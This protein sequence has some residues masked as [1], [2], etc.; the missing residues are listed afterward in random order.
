M[1]YFGKIIAKIAEIAVLPPLVAIFGLERAPPRNTSHLTA[2]AT[3]HWQHAWYPHKI[4]KFQRDC[5]R[6]M[7]NF[8]E[9]S[10]SET[11]S[12][13]PYQFEPVSCQRESQSSAEESETES[14]DSSSSENGETD[15]RAGNSDWW[16]KSSGLIK[17]HL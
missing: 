2:Q 10:D 5:L 14:S 8:D 17:C 1:V 13:E 6:I 11:F 3:T 7:E 4:R 12:I 9:E 15:H 16:A